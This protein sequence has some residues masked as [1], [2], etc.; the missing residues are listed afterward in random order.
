MT[1]AEQLRH[2]LW[3]K[4][5]LEILQRDDFEC[6]NCNDRETTLHVH[7]GT[8]IKG[9][10]L[11][12]VPDDT[13]I[14]LCEKCHDIFERV[15]SQF[16]LAF[17]SLTLDDQI[18]ILAETQAQRSLF[19]PDFEISFVSNEHFE[20]FLRSA[21]LCGDYKTRLEMYKVAASKFDWC[22]IHSAHDLSKFAF[23]FGLAEE[24]PS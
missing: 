15:K 24:V 13:L 17:G 8:Y 5:R 21:C 14:T 7:H 18:R 9:R 16:S 6:R 23:D 19:E 20:W 22:A 2:P 3:Q 1:Y 10:L 4:K 12:E 11:W